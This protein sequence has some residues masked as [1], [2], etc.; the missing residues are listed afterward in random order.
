MFVN[1]DTLTIRVVEGSVGEEE[2][3]DMSTSAHH[4]I[5]KR[6]RQFL[7]IAKL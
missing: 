3:K 2:D 4:Q 5:M 7:F 6:N 1:E